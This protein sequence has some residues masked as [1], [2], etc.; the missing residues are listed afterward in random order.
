MNPIKNNHDGGDYD[1]DLPATNGWFTVFHNPP[2]P[3][4]SHFIICIQSIIFGNIF[5]S[6]IAMFRSFARAWGKSKL[7]VNRR[8]E[9]PTSHNKITI[10]KKLSLKKSKKYICWPWSISGD[11]PIANTGLHDAKQC[12]QVWVFFFYS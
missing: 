5:W 12:T 9:I 1:K 11:A 4:F 3:A 10:T 8:V 2:Q 7:Y 6:I